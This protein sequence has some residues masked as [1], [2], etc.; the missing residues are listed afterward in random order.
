MIEKTNL[1]D[2]EKL[3]KL[4]MY[5]NHGLGRTNSTDF[6]LLHSLLIQC[7]GKFFYLNNKIPLL[8]FY[9]NIV[10]YKI[11]YKKLFLPFD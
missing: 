9:K 7:F 3:F 11:A 2:T 8:L 6:L 5:I 4:N 10:Q 1:P